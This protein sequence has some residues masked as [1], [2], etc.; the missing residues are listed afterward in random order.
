M[1]L[2]AGAARQTTLFA[3]QKAREMG[4]LVSYDPNYR[5]A[6]WSSEAEAVE[7]MK[8]PLPL[9]D[10]LKIS[11]EELPLVTGTADLARERR[12]SAIWGLP[13]CW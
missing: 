2:T 4:V 13:W 7:W 9:V 8:K 12:L 6:L 10:V 5:Q 3:A 1:S 11:E